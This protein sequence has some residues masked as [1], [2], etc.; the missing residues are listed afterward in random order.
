M[1]LIL[2]VLMFSQL[3]VLYEKV[4]IATDTWC[5]VVKRTDNL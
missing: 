1:G 2:S 3:L 5:N 4:R